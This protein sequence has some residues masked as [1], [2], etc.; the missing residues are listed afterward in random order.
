MK[1]IFKGFAIFLGCVTVLGSASVGIGCAVDNNFKNQVRQVF[2]IEQ[3]IKPN[4]NA[5]A[6]SK[7]ELISD[8]DNQI[9]NLSTQFEEFSSDLVQ[10]NVELQTHKNKLDELMADTDTNASEIEIVKASIT[11]LTTEINSV[12]ELLTGINEQILS[13][14]QTIEDLKA[15]VSKV[16]KVETVYDAFNNS[17]DSNYS[18][19]IQ[20]GVTVNSFNFA[21]YKYLRVFVRTNGA[22]MTMLIDLNYASG[23]SVTELGEVYFSS[24]VGLA[25]TGDGFYFCS[26]Y[27]NKAKNS[28]SCY[29]M[30]VYDNGEFKD[31]TINGLYSSSYFVYRIEGIF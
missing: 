12:N 31:R 1:K 17:L 22:V 30:G 28:F 20:G 25:V 16:E 10:K 5:S 8:L 3:T 18:S 23:T 9:K 4:K 13:I 15:E 26:C 21:K 2:K 14:Q 19:G 27:V 6:V 29:K 7:E 24:A 11:N